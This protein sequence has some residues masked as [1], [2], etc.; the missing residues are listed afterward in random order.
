M[1]VRFKD[2]D[3]WVNGDKTPTVKQLQSVATRA[4]APFVGRRRDPASGERRVCGRVGDDQR[5]RRLEYASKA[6]PDRLPWLCARRPA[7]VDRLRQW[8]RLEEL[9][10]ERTRVAGLVGATASTGGNFYNSKPL[11]VSKRFARELIASTFFTGPVPR[12]HQIE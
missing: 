8:L 3:A 9:R 12:V 6:Q 11:Q 10:L 7:R 1:T 4:H 5:H 2:Y